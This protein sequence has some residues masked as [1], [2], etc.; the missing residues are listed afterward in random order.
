[1][2]NVALCQALGCQHITVLIMNDRSREQRQ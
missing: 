1:M 2:M